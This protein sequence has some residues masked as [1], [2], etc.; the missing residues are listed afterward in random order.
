MQSK[1]KPCP[2]CGG[3]AELRT[4]SAYKTDFWVVKCSVCKAQTCRIYLDEPT[5]IPKYLAKPK[6]KIS[7]TNKQAQEIAINLWNARKE[8]EDEEKA[9]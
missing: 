5:F 3:K 4:A 6:E 1:L 2:F 7:Y 8:P 9:N